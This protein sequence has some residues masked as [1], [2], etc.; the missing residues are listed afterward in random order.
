MRAVIW[1][2]GLADSESAAQTICLVLLLYQLLQACTFS[3][4]P[5]M[6]LTYVNNTLQHLSGRL[7]K[8]VKDLPAPVVTVSAA[9]TTS[10]VLWKL[11]RSTKPQP[12]NAPPVVPYLLPFIGNGFQMAKDPAK[13]IAQCKEKYGPVFQL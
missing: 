2:F 13:F 7:Q 8:S 4:L 3:F 12:A 10:Y 6:S 5:R 9:L 1:L 11:I